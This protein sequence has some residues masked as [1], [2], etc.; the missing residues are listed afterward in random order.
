MHAAL[1]GANGNG[2]HAADRVDELE[3]ELVA[4]RQ[5]ARAQRGRG[6]RVAGSAA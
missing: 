6:L 2:A 5:K 3:A 4:E 1:T